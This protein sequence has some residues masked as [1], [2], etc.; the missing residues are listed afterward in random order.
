MNIVS[1]DTID[2][3]KQCKWIKCRFTNT[4]SWYTKTMYTIVFKNR[5]KRLQHFPTHASA[6]TISSPP[7]SATPIA[8]A[9]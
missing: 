8:Y 9:N 5:Q 4:I 2:L 1:S 3:L 7:P 6:F